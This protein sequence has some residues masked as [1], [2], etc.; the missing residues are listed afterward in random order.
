VKRRRLRI[1]VK[2]LAERLR[3]FRFTQA[4]D[5]HFRNAHAGIDRL[6]DTI[7]A[8]EPEAVFLTGDFV[9]R[10]HRLDPVVRFVSLL[11]PRFGVWAVMGNW[12]RN[13]IGWCLREDAIRRELS[14]AGAVLLN[15]EAQTVMAGDSALYVVGVD[16]A[17]SGRPDLE[18]ALHGVPA[19]ATKIL[20]S[21][22]PSVG[23]R[24]PKHGIAIALSG[25][26]HGGQFAMPGIPLMWL[27]PLERRYLAGLF[28]LGGSHLYVSRGVGTTGPPL[29][30][31]APNEIA[32]F[33]LWPEE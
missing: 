2:G 21:H 19:S 3:G 5:L 7:N 1:P 6:A 12:E 11:R 8:E 16:D 9:S 10:S 22:H 15:N 24:A 18:T 33:M 13:E 17:L 23:L 31:W 27:L 26:T 32:T 20:L 28:D 14:A 25:H 29:R 4:S 30:L